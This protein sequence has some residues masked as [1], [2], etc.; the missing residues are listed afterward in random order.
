M[1]TSTCVSCRTVAGEITPPGGLVHNTPEW[2]M[3][4]RSRPL[5][6][7]GQGFIVLRRH[8]EDVAQ[9]TEHE[10]GALGVLLRATARAY[11]EVLAPERVHFGL[12][13]EGV[14]HIH[15]HVL[16]RTRELPAGNIPLTLLGQWYE[17]LHRLGLRRPYDD[18]QVA[19]IASQLQAAFARQALDG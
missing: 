10:A 7:R 5:L 6:V 14:R 15:L 2:V 12:Y 13:G 16:P 1:A 8:C 19:S 3:F 4:L 9:L 11:T 17:V 18:T